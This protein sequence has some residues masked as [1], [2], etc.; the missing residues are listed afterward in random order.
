MATAKGSWPFTGLAQ[1]FPIPTA[2]FINVDEPTSG[3]GYTSLLGSSLSWA[4]GGVNTSKTAKRPSSANNGKSKIPLRFSRKKLPSSPSRGKIYPVVG[5]PEGGD[6]PFEIG[7]RPSSEA[8]AKELLKAA[9]GGPSNVVID[10]RRQ[11]EK[12]LHV[13]SLLSAERPTV[14]LTTIFERIAKKERDANIDIHGHVEKQKDIF[15]NLLANPAFSSHMPIPVPRLCYQQEKRPAKLQISDT[16]IQADDPAHDWLESN[17]LLESL[18]D[19][20][21]TI[22]MELTILFRSV[23]ETDKRG[24]DLASSAYATGDKK[25]LESHFF[26]ALRLLKRLHE[27]LHCPIRAH[28]KFWMAHNIISSATLVAILSRLCHLNKCRNFLIDIFRL[29]AKLTTYKENGF[30]NFSHFPAPKRPLK[31]VLTK[32]RKSF[33]RNR[34]NTIVGSSQPSISKPSSDP[35]AALTALTAGESHGAKDTHAHHDHKH[36]LTAFFGQAPSV[37]RESARKSVKISTELSSQHQGNGSVNNA[38]NRWSTLSRF[39]N[40]TINT[41]ATAGFVHPNMTSTVYEARELESD[42][43]EDEDFDDYDDDENADVMGTGVDDVL[44]GVGGPINVTRSPSQ[45]LQHTSRLGRRSVRS[46]LRNSV[47]SSGPRLSSATNM[48]RLSMAS[49]GATSSSNGHR[50]TRGTKLVQLTSTNPDGGNQVKFDKLAEERVLKA[51]IEEWSV[52][53]PWKVSGFVIN[54]LETLIRYLCRY[55]LLSSEPWITSVNRKKIVVSNNLNQFA[56]EH[57][58]RAVL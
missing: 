47:R 20:D 16:N 54:V 41:P 57:M 21:D 11:D 31:L 30:L 5:W 52:S 18:V 25:F 1:P 2:F 27:D 26:N 33:S 17:V 13:A 56:F 55:T 24:V 32:S 39:S 34:S 28:Q 51:W 40:I 45:L 53:L 19:E 36:G 4:V 43:E 7:Q 37:I 15:L 14:I 9:A 6:L 29:A 42:D 50:P 48:S 12:A 35:F 10:E 38:Y 58:L 22:H 49:S 46:S 23:C 44:A 3:H 8:E